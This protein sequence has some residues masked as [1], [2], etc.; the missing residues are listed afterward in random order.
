MRGSGDAPSPREASKGKNCASAGVVAGTPAQQ[1]TA[2]KR[3]I[4]SSPRHDS[5]STPEDA[6]VTTVLS[7]DE[8]GRRKGSGGVGSP[9]AA[10]ANTPATSVLSNPSSET[11]RSKRSSSSSSSGRA[12]CP[13][14]SPPWSQARNSAFSPPSSRRVAG[15]PGRLRSSPGLSCK[16]ESAGSHSGTSSPAGGTGVV[17]KNPR[18]SHGG[19]VEAGSS[20]T[21]S[22]G[23][24]GPSS[25][26]RRPRVDR[27]ETTAR[28]YPPIRS[29][30]CVAQG[31]PEHVSAPLP[32]SDHNE[33]EARMEK[34]RERALKKLADSPDFHGGGAF[35]PAGSISCVRTCDA[36][37]RSVT[38]SGSGGRRCSRDHRHHDGDGG[39]AK[40]T[41][42]GGKARRTDN[43]GTPSGGSRKEDQRGQKR[44]KRRGEDE[45]GRMPSMGSRSSRD[46]AK[47]GVAAGGTAEQDTE[48]ARGGGGGKSARAGRRRDCSRASP[49]ARSTR[50]QERLESEN[51]RSPV[52]SS[53]GDRESGG[54]KGGTRS[55]RKRPTTSTAGR[56][57]LETTGDSSD[58]GGDSGAGDAG[59]QSS[60]LSGRHRSV[61]RSL[62][63][64]FAED[65]GD[66]TAP[67]LWRK[68][69]AVGGGNSSESGPPGK[70][71]RATFSRSPRLARA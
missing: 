20:T 25:S 42:S 8:S 53:R 12:R 54:S 71:A 6:C 66:P 51:E 1:S 15:N 29:A 2:T 65:H 63:L 57:G 13:S 46:P 11:G 18:A 23:G 62:G 69:A 40:K 58:D 37:G 59:Q 28:E 60:P 5:S 17:R 68:R 9:V 67:D 24:S 3:R 26:R 34:K 50:E 70:R 31:K 49:D 27:T 41:G 61:P 64:R 36:R 7:R 43:L 33:K 39:S 10:V 4:R 16:R 35:S 21:V 55:C 45:A 47:G 52:G 38:A 32:L 19:S 30:P 48:G 14:E 44:R 22:R 56:M